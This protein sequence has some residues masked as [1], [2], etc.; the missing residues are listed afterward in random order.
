M[1]A[2][3]VQE[4]IC[5]ESLLIATS[6]PCERAWLDVA[7]RV[8]AMLDKKLVESRRAGFRCPGCR[9]IHLRNAASAITVDTASRSERDFA[10]PTC[11]LSL[12]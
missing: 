4:C 12:N 3:L 9:R 8:A 5:G 10:P 7:A 1:R 2:L 11:E 6:E